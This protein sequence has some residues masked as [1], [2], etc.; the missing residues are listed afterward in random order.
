MR[1]AL[2]LRATHTNLKAAA[3]LAA[4]E[5][6]DVVR[7]FALLG[8]WRDHPGGQAALA[9]APEL[10]EWTEGGI[11]STDYMRRGRLAGLPARAD[12]GLLARC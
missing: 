4:D 10:G 8:R 6:H 2:V 9:G 5:D 7:L 11:F 3:P 12:D 1:S